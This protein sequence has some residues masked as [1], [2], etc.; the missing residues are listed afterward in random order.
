MSPD[1]DDVG[2][3]RDAPAYAGAMGSSGMKRR[4]RKHLP[5]VEGP[6]APTGFEHSPYTFEGTVERMGAFARGVNA[7]RRAHGRARVFGIALLGF[8]LLIILT[9][10]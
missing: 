5:K 2:R 10:I 4:G 7:R 8:V 1:R 6:I 3:R 9:R